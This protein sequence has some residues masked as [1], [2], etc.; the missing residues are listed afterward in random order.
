MYD[1]IA[2]VFRGD[3]NWPAADAEISSKMFKYSVSDNATFKV[4]AAWWVVVMG[5]EG[6]AGLTEALKQGGQ[7]EKFLL[8]AK[9]AWVYEMATQ[10]DEPAIES[11]RYLMKKFREW[12]AGAGAKAEGSSG[13]CLDD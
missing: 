7:W 5:I 1:A 11:L 13:R 9:R 8:K 4:S 12:G 2:L 10:E 3:E 6:H